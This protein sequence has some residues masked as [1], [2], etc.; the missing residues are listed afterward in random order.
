MASINVGELIVVNAL[1]TQ[2]ELNNK[3]ITVGGV[4]KNFNFPVVF[5][6]VGAGLSASVDYTY[7]NAVDAPVSS[8][9]PDLSFIQSLNIVNGVLSGVKLALTIPESVTDIADAAFQGDGIS[10][11]IS[12]VSFPDSLVSI[13]EGAFQ[14]N[15]ITEVTLPESCSYKASSFDVG[16]TI[17]GGTLI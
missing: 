16:V 4:T 3:S 8:F 6:R 5:R 1:P 10:L 9:N 7:R 14:N 15:L 2:T 13:G 11:A 17:T 12:E